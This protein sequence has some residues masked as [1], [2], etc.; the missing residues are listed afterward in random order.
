MTIWLGK[1]HQPAGVPLCA[2]RNR[3]LALSRE[4]ISR[5]PTRQPSVE[6]DDELQRAIAMSEEEA[7]APKRQKREETPEEERRMLE[8]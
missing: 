3:A 2:E 8:E 7:R 5:P 4:E 1:A 6:E